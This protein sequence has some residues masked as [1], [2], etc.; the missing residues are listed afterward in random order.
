MSE[1][2]RGVGVG[3]LY[4]VQ[5]EIQGEKIPGAA[6]SRILN[7]RESGKGGGVWGGGRVGRGPGSASDRG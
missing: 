4:R 2:V 7:W 3:E 6:V 1:N 5:V